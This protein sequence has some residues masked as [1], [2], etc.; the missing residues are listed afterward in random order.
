MLFVVTRFLL[1][2]ADFAL[3]NSNTFYHRQQKGGQL[4]K[5]RV[6]T[7]EEAYSPKT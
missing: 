7:Y 6:K 5:H 3:Q 4:N 2:E 1:G